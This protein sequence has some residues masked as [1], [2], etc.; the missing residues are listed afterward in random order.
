MPYNPHEPIDGP[1]NERYF[2]FM[3]ALIVLAVI[4]FVLGAIVGGLL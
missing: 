4:A 1:G 2:K 3:V